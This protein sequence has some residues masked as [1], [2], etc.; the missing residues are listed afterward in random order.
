MVGSQIVK[1]GICFLLHFFSDV[2]KFKIM[3]NEVI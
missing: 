2:L 3:S 1:V